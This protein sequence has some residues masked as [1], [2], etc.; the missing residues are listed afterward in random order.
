M[1][2]EEN[3]QIILTTTPLAPLPETASIEDITARAKDLRA[4]ELGGLW[5]L[6]EA[7]LAL[8]QTLEL[9]HSKL[10][11]RKFAEWLDEVKIPQDLWRA[12]VMFW[13]RRDI[14]REELTD[15]LNGQKLLPG[16]VPQA[17]AG[18]PDPASDPVA[19]AAER[20]EVAGIDFSAMPHLVDEL[21][22]KEKNVI[23]GLRESRRFIFVLAQRVNS[24]AEPT[25]EDVEKIAAIRNT[26]AA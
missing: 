2:T 12:Y 11:A 23:A 1:K 26:L 4:V 20:G 25:A 13:T 6:T 22:S 3:T 8:G 19:W 17:P 9:A 18:Q 10:T 24:G 21:V 15:K 7:R 14:V 5:G 16:V